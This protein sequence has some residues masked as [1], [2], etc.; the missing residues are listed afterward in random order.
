M[1]RERVR[2]TSVFVALV[3]ATCLSTAC[4]HV[5]KRPFECA[6]L[7]TPAG[8]SALGWQRTAGT[9]GVSGKIVAPGSLVP[10]QGAGITLIAML[11]QG[12]SETRQAYSD[13]SG[14]FRIDSVLPARYLM[15]VRRLGY[16]PARDTVEL[17]PDSGIVATAVL[18]PDNIVLDECSMTYYEVRVPWWKRK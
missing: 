8:S 9:L 11:N 18:I 15:A 6:P 12:R 5:V 17:K 7:P 3:G 4:T 14:G 2:P 1:V 10:I 13:A 16:S